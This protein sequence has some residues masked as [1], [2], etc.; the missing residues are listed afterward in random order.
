MSFYVQTVWIWIVSVVQAMLR[1]RHLLIAISV[2]A[3]IVAIL[4][5]DQ[6]GLNDVD[7]I[8]KDDVPDELKDLIEVNDLTEKYG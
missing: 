3:G 2:L 5:Q 4:G 1:R 8:N 7:K 6:E